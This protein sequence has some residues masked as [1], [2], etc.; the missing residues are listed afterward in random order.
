MAAVVAIDLG[1]VRTGIALG[2]D[3]IRIA[4]PLEVCPTKELENR[5]LDIIKERSIKILVMGVALN[6]D[7]TE[8]AMSQKARAFARRIKRRANI[9]T[10]FVDEYASSID[11]VDRFGESNI[12]GINA[13]DAHAAAIILDRFFTSEK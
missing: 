6:A 13:T 11:S 7:G 12:S 1:K 4:H 2:D 9:K 3:L 8:S 10:A 5:L